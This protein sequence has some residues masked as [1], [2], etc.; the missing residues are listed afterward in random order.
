MIPLLNYTNL[1]KKGK[2]NL[3]DRNIHIEAFKI[4]TDL[5]KFSPRPIKFWECCIASAF[6]SFNK[7]SESPLIINDNGYVETNLLYDIKESEI[8]YIYNEEKDIDEEKE[9]IINKN[10][11]EVAYDLYIYGNF[12][13]IAD[14]KIDEDL[15]KSLFTLKTIKE[16]ENFILNEFRVNANPSVNEPKISFANTEI[17]EKNILSSILGKPNLSSDRYNKLSKILKKSRE[18][19]TDVLL[20]PECFIPFNLLSTLSR[21]SVDNGILVVSGLEHL[22]INKTSFN[23]VVSIIPFELNGIKDSTVILRLKNNY[24]PNEEHSINKYHLKVPKPS[25]NRYEI[26]NW[27]NMYFS[28]CYCFEMANITHREAL[29]GKID[30]LIGIEWNKDTPYFSNIVESSSRDLHCYVAQVNTSNYGDTR[31]TQP[32]ETAIKDILRLK[33]GTNDTILVGEIFIKKLRD[34]QRIKS[35]INTSKE[36]KPL[37]PD[38]S[39]D[40]VMKRIKNQ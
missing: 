32:K 1:S 30:L 38:F 14:Y 13:H 34:F 11:L 28:V 22:T 3:V 27:R 25:P 20:F 10:Y 18:E 15:E 5:L 4:N 8:E 39:L 17:L 16:N 6:Q 23:Y 33:G 24:S 26:I 37:P 12:N 9:V 19:N 7:F 2:I 40:E 36:Y 31:L 21:Y 29:K 35:S